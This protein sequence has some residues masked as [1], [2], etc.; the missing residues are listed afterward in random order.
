MTSFKIR[1]TCALCSSEALRTVM[2]LPNT[3]L[4]NAFVTDPK[5]HI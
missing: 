2:T 5:I 1:K 3:P 4:A